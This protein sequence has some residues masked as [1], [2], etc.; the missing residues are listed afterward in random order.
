MPETVAS[1]ILSGIL[2]TLA[3]LHF[4]GIVHRDLKPANILLRDPMNPSDVVLI[5]FGSSFTPGKKP[6]VAGAECSS[7]GAMKTICGTPYFLSPELTRGEDYSAKVDIWAVGCLAYTM[8]FGKSPFADSGSYSTLYSRISR[9]DYSF[10]ADVNGP[11]ETARWF[12]RSLLEA[13]PAFRPEAGQAL[14]HPWISPPTPSCEIGTD[15]A[16]AD[17][18]GSGML[19]TFDEATGSLMVNA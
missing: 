7:V 19:V 4:L 2:Y 11:S 16:G 1:D 12:V 9:A 6:P 17:R 14:S 15:F 8:L 10:P 13:V 3:R 5:D 18:F